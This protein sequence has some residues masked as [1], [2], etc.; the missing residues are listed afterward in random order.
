MHEYDLII[1]G[2]GPA[3]Y[4]AALHAA[5]LGVKT[6]VIEKEV[7]GGECLNYACIPLKTL[8][9]Y[10]ILKSRIVDLT[11][12]GLYEGKVKINLDVLKRVKDG[13]VRDLRKN[14][15]STM[16]R[17]GISIVYGEAVSVYDHI[18][19]V[20]TRS[21]Y[22]EFSGS[23]VFLAMGSRPSQLPNVKFDGEYIVS[24]KQL[25]SLSDVPKKLGI[26]GGGAVG[27]EIA[28]LYSILGS[29]V[30]IIEL[31]P[32]LIPMFDKDIAKRLERS[33]KRKGVK[34]FLGTRVS[35]VSIKNG[36]VQV[37]ALRDGELLSL[38][39]DKILISIGRK[40]NTHYSF[41]E[42]L[43]IKL[44]EMGYISVD[45]SQ[46]TDVNWIY[47]G[48]DITGPPMVAH[49]AYW[50]GLNMVESAFRGVSLRKPRYFPFTIYSDPEIFSIGVSDGD[51]GLSLI[52]IPVTISGKAYAEGSTGLIKILVDE[53]DRVI[54]GF[55]IISEVASSLSCLP[56]L[57][58]QNKL[59][60]DYIIKTI[61]PHPTY[62]EAIWE[63]IASLKR[64]SIHYE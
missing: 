56:S 49:K 36:R 39:F 18:V 12:K 42:K 60:Y 3:G 23:K 58:V 38:E 24:S 19:R 37:D 25:I 16:E 20:R 44:D 33:L 21:G 11:E 22:S 50:V 34:L 62:S 61:F 9:H 10:T 55:H 46:R 13:V 52:K 15:E 51:E 41:I 29:D 30:T 57:L 26:I 28:T 59:E 14:L 48:G 45:E 1:I 2:S 47:A 6:L 31:M 7:L 4:S 40:P 64:L 63:A 8:L 43:G 53:K 54:K 17:L 32:T 35:R 27:V 5:R